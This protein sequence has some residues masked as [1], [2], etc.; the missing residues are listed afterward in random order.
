[1]SLSFC[2]KTAWSIAGISFK[3]AF[4]LG[5]PSAITDSFFLRP[6][7]SCCGCRVL[8]F[9]GPV[10]GL[11]KQTDDGGVAGWMGIE[12]HNAP[13]GDC[14]GSHKVRVGSITAV[15]AKRPKCMI[16]VR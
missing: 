11:P 9:K 12:F 6:F 7:S 10:W 1:M 2:C 5:L 8:Q 15:L 13:H 14:D 16:I 4:F 3:E